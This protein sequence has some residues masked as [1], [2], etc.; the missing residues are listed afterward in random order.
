M[1]TFARNFAALAAFASLAAVCLVQPANSAAISKESVSIHVHAGVSASHS[2]GQARATAVAARSISLHVGASASESH[3]RSR[4]T[5]R[6]ATDSISI[7][8]H[9]GVSASH[10]S[11]TRQPKPTSDAKVSVSFLVI[12]CTHS[13]LQRRHVARSQADAAPNAKV[14]ITLS[15]LDTISFVFEEMGPTGP[16][17]ASGLNV[18]WRWKWMWNNDN[19][20]DCH[21]VPCHSQARSCSLHQRPQRQCIL[22]DSICHS[23]Q[24]LFEKEL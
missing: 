9:A 23:C 13:S 1:V 19:D 20:Q 15:C 12:I 3:G 22:G 11:T 14:G 6:A 4:S 18:Y 17:S 16:S 21:L 24:T 2:R 7:H 8:A 10:H 5:T